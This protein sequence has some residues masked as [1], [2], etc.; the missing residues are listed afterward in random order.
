MQNYFK[1]FLVIF[2]FNLL[3][4]SIELNAKKKGGSNL[5]FGPTGIIGV[6]SKGSIKVSGTQKG[7]PADGKLKKGD[8]IV[9][10]GENKL[11][12]NV[13]RDLAKAID[14]A[15]TQSAAGKMILVLK[16]NENIEII[17]PTL[18][19]Y[20]K[21]APYN[22]PKTDKI[23]TM[24]A[25][26]LLKGK[27]NSR[28]KVELLGLMATGEKKY[29]D[30]AA[31][32]IK[33]SDYIKPDQEAIKN[34]LIGEKDMGY[35]TWS[36]GYQVIMLAEYF[37]LTKDDTVLPAIKAYAV[38]LAKGQDAGGLWGHRLISPKRNF[39]LPGYGQMNQP[40]LSCFNALILARKCGIK[41][42]HLD[43]GIA[44]TKAYIESHINKGGFPYGVHGPNDR[45]YNNNGTSG[46]AAVAM[47]LINNKEGAKFFSQ[48]AS[49]SFDGLESGHASTFFNPLW[50]PLGTNL[51]GPEVSHQFF[52][53]SLWFHNMRRSHDGAWHVKW[54][55]GPHHGLALLAYCVGRKALYIT[56]KESDESIYLKGKDA[57][58]VV[59][60]SKIDFKSKSIDELLLL[61]MN[62]QL[63]QV[64]RGAMGALGQ[65]RE[66]LT[67]KYKKFFKEG[68][69]KE[70]KL[71]ISQYGWWLPIEQRLSVLVY[72]ADILKNDKES[73][74]V[75]MAAASSIAYMKEHAIKFYPDIVKLMALP[76]SND[77]FS[78]KNMSLG[79]ALNVIS[80]KPFTDGLVKNK[81]EHYKV[82]LD[83]VRHKRQHAR[84]EGLKM[85]A[86]IPIEDFHRLADDILH[87]VS[88]KDP[89]YHSYHNPGGPVTAAISILANLNI[90]EGIDLAM[91]IE[92]NPSGKGSFKMKATWACLQQY[93]ANAKE[94]LAE[95]R[96]RCNNRT[97]WG[98][99]TR[100]F[101]NM[102][103]LIE[104]D[105]IPKKL[106]S[107]EEVLK[108][109]K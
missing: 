56:G 23:I 52:K 27:L 89:T 81:E 65:H 96:K 107:M 15:E 43:K 17:L 18:G 73:L 5:T 51:S 25:D 1:T 88:D 59:L 77:P 28:L 22:C 37:L 100:A 21:T 9:G 41:D 40:S 83:L 49:T 38:A 13:V 103:K 58:A 16:G 99:H 87:I 6:A 80:N 48:I 46:S 95:Y 42:P 70:K 63:P 44:K 4:S 26:N 57:E 86:D 35:V 3:F 106:I 33:A 54:K 61:A 32:I 75:R 64:R 10:I 60:N 91:K 47:A 11:S 30:A 53:R 82:A 76:K 2:I 90:R 67:P 84:S 93:G 71:A 79:R 66:T 8:V 72:I 85:L 31:K 78:L 109:G 7:S 39:R 69:D 14:I 19:T 55:E 36:W 68:N 45:T 92:S 102:V 29:I 50:T 12:N 34:L 105:K 20:S 74:D 101:N 108:A 97:D 62:H 98:R 24:T 94:A 104:N